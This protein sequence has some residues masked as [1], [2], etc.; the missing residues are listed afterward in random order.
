[1]ASRDDIQNGEGSF[2]VTLREDEEHVLLAET[3][4]EL[5]REVAAALDCSECCIY[6]YVPGDETLRAVAIWSRRLTARDRA[7]V[8]EVHPLADIPDFVPVISGREVVVSYPEDGID[9]ATA[10]FES[11]SYWGELAAVWAPIVRGDEVLGILELTEKERSRTFDETE[12]RLVARLASMA[13][14][15]LRNARA[16]R[17]VEVRNRQLTALID[18]SR[19][20]L[21]TLDIDEVL[22][23]VCRQ[24]ALALD[25]PR[26]YIYEYDND[27]DAMVWVAG[28]ESDPSHR[29]EEPLGTVYP[30]SELPDVSVL[31]T[32]RP[33]AYR[34]DDPSLP[35]ASR[36]Q[37]QDWDQAS[38]L[39]V[40][41]V[42]GDLIL[43]T[44]EVSEST[45][46]RHFT[47]QEVDLCVA[48]G[49]QAAAAIHNAR[50]YRRLQEQ[51]ST[52]ELQA[53]TDALTGLA[54]HRHFWDRLRDEV[55][56][57]RRY[58]ESL[59]LLMLDVDDFK[60]VND[61]L[62]HPAGDA[63]LHAVG[64][65]LREQ[66]RQGVDL[67]ARYGGEEFAVVLPS[68]KSV[69]DDGVTFDGAVTTAERIR[70][71]IAAMHP[72]LAGGDWTGITVSVG[73]A[74]LPAHAV[75]AEDLVGK[76]DVAL[77][78]AKNAGKD[79]VAVF[80]AT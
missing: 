48:L 13:G 20:M 71:A 37:M 19:A 44:L 36:R 74:T 11:I 63:V 8:G 16:T 53:T 30:L 21:S 29:F 68:T 60:H 80:G 45:E 31:R 65:V 59:S 39:M 41:L 43:G 78:A 51:K 40:P 69:L 77:Y 32:R 14:L 79:R 5:A 4:A 54:N 17:D 61:S 12:I 57:A 7:W 9:A 23:I 28:H 2:A 10:G 70:T 18:S 72:P 73:V 58:G 75:D 33:V 67:P 50:L 47:E 25:A 66:I 35:P 64:E 42:V 22:Q 55:V 15:A 76:A 24:V 38:S 56:R 49:E 27:A 34:I 46:P 6:D 1:M 52:I 26:A 3:L 62:G